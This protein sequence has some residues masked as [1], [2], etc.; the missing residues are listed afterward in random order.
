MNLNAILALLLGL[1]LLISSLG[2]VRVVYFVSIGYAFSI[3]A[4]A[5]VTPILLRQ[6]LTW[7]AT[8]QNLL[9]SLWGLRLGIYLVRRESAT[10]YRGASWRASSNAARGSA[11]PEVR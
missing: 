10:S 6:N 2:F 11:A 5:I 9:L 4:M 7:T 3:V 8:A 1:A